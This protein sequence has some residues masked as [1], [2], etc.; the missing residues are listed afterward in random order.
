MTDRDDAVD[1]VRPT[2]VPHSRQ[3]GR[4][5][6]KSGQD[7]QDG[8][9][10]TTKLNPKK[11]VPQAKRRRRMPVPATRDAAHAVFAPLDDNARARGRVLDRLNA[12]GAIALRPAGGEPIT[13]GEA[14]EA[15]LD[16]LYDEHGQLRDAPTTPVQARAI[17]Q[18]DV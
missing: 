9:P 5:M 6:P 2:P 14:H 10:A 17:H 13:R 3:S 15:L 11:A 12:L 8:T 4:A 7:G 1:D 18:S 16:E